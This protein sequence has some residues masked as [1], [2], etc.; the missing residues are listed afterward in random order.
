M[1]KEFRTYYTINKN[2]DKII[3]NA[4][5]FKIS[6]STEDKD[7]VSDILESVRNHGAI[8]KDPAGIIRHK[9]ILRKDRYLGELSERMLHKH[10]Q[11]EIDQSIRIDRFSSVDPAQHIDLRI[12]LNDTEKDIEIRSSFI[13]TP[14][15]ENSNNP[16]LNKN[17]VIGPYTTEYKHKEIFKDYYLFCII[18]QNVNDFNPF[19]Y[20]EL[21]FLAGAEKELFFKKGYEGN[22]KQG[23]A[24][25]YHLIFIPEARDAKKIVDI[26]KK[27]LEEYL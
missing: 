6:P 1:E 8:T 21:M 11:E 2:G 19:S 5:V 26:I 12:Q 16:V 10:L 22:L 27:D 4:C 7:L 24:T 15:Y 20:H 14:L 17:N 25:K 13:Y 18:N 23:D 9:D 3:T